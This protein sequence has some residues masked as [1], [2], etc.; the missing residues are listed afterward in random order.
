M[1]WVWEVKHLNNSVADVARRRETA[2]M[3]LWRNDNA[4]PTQTEIDREVDTILTRMFDAWYMGK[5]LS[6]FI[7]PI[8]VSC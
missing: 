6:G 3:N 2:E 1:R 5:A 8:G 4:N 7:G